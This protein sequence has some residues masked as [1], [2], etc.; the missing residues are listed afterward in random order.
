[1]V[2]LWFEFPFSF[3]KSYFFRRHCTG[4]WKGFYFSLCYAFLRTTMIAK[5]LERASS[6]DKPQAAS[7]VQLPRFNSSRRLAIKAAEQSSP[8][9]GS[10]GAHP[11]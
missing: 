6:A 3:V 9:Q 11:F 7:V 2:R 1:M 10:T 5:M 4:G 8:V